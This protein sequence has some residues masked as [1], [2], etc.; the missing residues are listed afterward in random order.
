[1]ALN[2]LQELYL[3]LLVLCVVLVLEILVS[4]PVRFDELHRESGLPGARPSRLG[5]HEVERALD[6]GAVADTA[7]SSRWVTSDSTGRCERR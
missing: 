6:R 4:R 1:M 5:H 2:G 7:V 3:D